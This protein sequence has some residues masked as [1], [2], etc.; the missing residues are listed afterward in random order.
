MDLTFT[1]RSGRV[2][3]RGPGL[4]RRP[5]ARRTA[6]LPG[7]RGGLR[8]APRVGGAAA[9]GPL[10]GGVLARRSTAAGAPTS[11]V[12]GLRGGVLRGGRP[13]PGLAERHQPARPDPLRPRD[14]TEQRARVLPPMASGEVI[15]AQAWSEPEVGL[16]PGVAD[17]PRGAHGRRLAA[18]RAEDLVV[19]G[20]V[21]GPGVR[22]LPYGPDAPKP[23]QGLTYLMFDLSGAG[24]DRPADRA[25]RRQA[26]LRRTLPGRGLRTGRGRD[27]RA[28]PGLADRHVDH[29]Q[30]ARAD[31]ALP[32]PLPGRRGPAG[33]AVAHARRPVGHGAAGPGRGRGDRGARVPAVHLR[34]CL[35][36]RGG[37]DDRRRVQ[38]EQG[39]LVGVRH[40]AAR[41]G[42]RSARPGRRARGGRVGARGTSSPS[43]G[44]IYA[45]TNEIQRDIIAERL[46]GLPKGRR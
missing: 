9:R 39:V 16:R 34:Q 20:R 21:R 24:G 1:R 4:A 11:S 36:L 25:A 5:C 3:G 15:W 7:D 29:G 41:D 38:S 13:R 19:T 32:R 44:P 27:R 6:A 22:D 28:G 8:R 30:R 2:P 26:G 23:H 18:V 10:V 35:A 42:A 17:V 40:R 31:A 14:A 12:A 45:G 33:R 43:P 37:R 46:L